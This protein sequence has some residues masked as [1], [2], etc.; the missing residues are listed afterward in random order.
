MAAFTEMFENLREQC[1]QGR[2]NRRKLM[3]DLKAD[4]AAMARQTA[5]QLSTQSQQRQA[6]FTAMMDTVRDTVNQ[7]AAQT[8]QQLADLAAD[9]HRGGALF[10]Q[11]P[12]TSRRRR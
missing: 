12:T 3:G 8:R 11:K 7:Q 9:L 4:V 6:D 10:H 1:D 5:D 2:Q